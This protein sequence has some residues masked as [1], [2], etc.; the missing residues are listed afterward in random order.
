VLPHA[1]GIPASRRASLRSREVVLGPLPEGPGTGRL[2]RGPGRNLVLGLEAAVKIT[3]WKGVFVAEHLPGEEKYLKQA[4]FKLHEP[5]LC[6][7]AVCRGCRARIGRRYWS[8]RVEDATRLH[9]YC[10]PAAREVMK[11]HLRKLAQSRAVDANI[12]VPSPPGLAYKPYQRAGV[13]YALSRKD[14]LFGDDMGLGKTVEALAVANTLKPRS[15]LVVCPATITRNWQAEAMKWLVDGDRYAYLFP[16][17]TDQIPTEF[18]KPTIVIAN[19]EKVAA[20]TTRKKRL[21]ASSIKYHLQP[22]E[23]ALLRSLLTDK[24]QIAKLYEKSDVVVAPTPDAELPYL[25]VRG[26]LYLAMAAILSRPHI[27]AL[28][29]PPGTT[30]VDE[31]RRALHD[32]PLSK[33]LRRRW[34]LAIFDECQAL[35]NP[36]SQ[37]S[38]AILGQGGIYSG[39]RRALFLSGTPFENCPREIWPLAAALCPAKFGQWWPFARRYCGLHVEKRGKKNK[40]VADG[41]T[42][43]SELQQKLRTTFM[44]RR[45]KQDVLPELPPKRR[46]LVVL[47]EQVDW[48]K[49]PE[50]ARWHALYSRAVDQAMERLAAARTADEYRHAAMMLDTVAVRFEENSDVRHK[51]GLLKLPACLRFTDEILESGL[52]CLVIYA[53]HRDVL[54]KI[55]E[56][57]GEKS[58]VI[59]GDTPMQ[60]RFSIVEQFQSGK[61]QV[62]VGGLRAAGTGITLT[63]AWTVI[64][65]ETDWNPA[66]MVQAED[67]LCR[68]GQAKMVQVIHP[69]LDGSLDANMIKKILLKQ[70]MVD[71]V[72]N[73]HPELKTASP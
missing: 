67:R 2:R 54:E 59:Y 39:A 29:L 25:A 32:T 64:F 1:S 44:I 19:Y 38:R 14:T 17:T 56:H 58:C 24:E 72:L 70:E 55:H 10:L 48:T 7:P 47:D 35:K 46:Q 62:F 11:H 60:D 49:Y 22:S 9:R 50:F 41:C 6:E 31:A 33:S 68:I 71:K 21:E 3:F 51:T 27:W 34:D 23:A 52:D 69:V 40:W 63:R 57:Y 26:S 16:E 13:A 15:V 36:E 18:S 65:F 66:T 30:D 61:K 53:H 8:P 4:G 45:L 42:H 43:S 12:I 20:T 28:V 5:T 73:R 37:R